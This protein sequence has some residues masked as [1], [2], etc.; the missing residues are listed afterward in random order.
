MYYQT[1]N[2]MKRN[3]KAEREDGKKLAIFII[4]Y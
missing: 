2:R 1:V 4:L 3:K